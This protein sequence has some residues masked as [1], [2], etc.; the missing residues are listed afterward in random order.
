MLKV[1]AQL[2]SADMRLHH[3]VL[4]PLPR[5]CLPACLQAHPLLPHRRPQRCRLPRPA[6]RHAAPAGGQ[7]WRQ[8][9]PLSSVLSCAAVW[10]GPSINTSCSGCQPVLTAQMLL[11]LPVARRTPLSAH[12]PR[13]HPYAYLPQAARRNP[14]PGQR[15]ASDALHPRLSRDLDLLAPPAAGQCGG[16]LP[17]HWRH[18]C[19][20]VRCHQLQLRAVRCTGPQ[21]AAK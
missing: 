21:A 12:R 8:V 6:A 19:G 5:A 13:I 14:R 3:R 15:Q 2:L 1:L 17:Q 10:H 7:C 16:V 20:T 4:A 9:R 18:Q 11:P